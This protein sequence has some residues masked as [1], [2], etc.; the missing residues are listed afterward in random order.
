MTRLKSLLFLL[1]IPL[2]IYSQE[3]SYLE[4]VKAESR[5][6]LLFN[7]LYSDSLPDV[8]PILDTIRNEMSAVLGMEGSMDYPWSHLNKIGII[9]SEDL[10]V[11]VF[12][13]HVMD[14]YDHYRYFGYMQVAMKRGKSRL[15][16]LMDNGKP[17]RGVT[18]LDQTREDWYGKLYYQVLT[19]SYKRKTYYTLLGMDFNNSLS[20]IKSVEA[21][22]IQR[23]EP[24][25]VRSLFFNGRDK[26]DRL[27]LEYSNQ[28]AISVRYNPGTDMIT[29]DH[30]VPTHPIYEKNFEFYGPDGSFDGLE[31]SGG[32]WNYRED[33]DARNLD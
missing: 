27:L 33:I 14:D 20:I 24:Q 23:N 4:F 6:Q 22:Q 5:L 7:Q 3:P 18:R 29:F 28:V 10:R 11:R 21:I 19:N 12:S 1:I 9:T 25:F 31:F 16:E 32:V 8:E 26:V 2:S 30:L 13:W 15:F 17:Q